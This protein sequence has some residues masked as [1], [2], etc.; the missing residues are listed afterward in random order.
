MLPKIK[1]LGLKFNKKIQ[2]ST[3]YAKD[4]HLLQIDVL[5]Q[6]TGGVL[7]FHDIEAP[8]QFNQGSPL[9]KHRFRLTVK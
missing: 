3:I 9:D 8:V 4:I 7:K 2:Q 5:H 1:E 6:L